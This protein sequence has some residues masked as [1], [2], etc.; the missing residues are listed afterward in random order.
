MQA[1]AVAWLPLRLLASTLLALL[2]QHPAAA[3]DWECP[4]YL[5]QHEPAYADT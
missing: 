5:W 3:G 2:K 1:A 4:A